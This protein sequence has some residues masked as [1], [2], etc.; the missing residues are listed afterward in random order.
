MSGLQLIEAEHGFIDLTN[1]NGAARDFNLPQVQRWSNEV[2]H[3]YCTVNG[4][5]I[6]GDNLQPV[7]W[8]LDGNQLLGV[9]TNELEILASSS[10]VIGGWVGVAAPATY[11]FFPHP[12]HLP[13]RLRFRVRNDS[14]SDTSVHVVVFY[15]RVQI[16]AADWSALMRRRAFERD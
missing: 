7:V 9:P 1:G 13:G 2:W 6:G 3:L 4:G 11:S 10:L 8:G 16:P 5:G 12:L 14:G 15:R